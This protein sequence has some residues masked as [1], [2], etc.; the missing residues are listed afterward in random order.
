MKLSRRMGPSPA[1]LLTHLSI[2]AALVGG[3]TWLVKVNNLNDVIHAVGILVACFVDLLWMLRLNADHWLAKRI[4]KVAL[5]KCESELMYMSR[6]MLEEA[7]EKYVRAARH[8]EGGLKIFLENSNTR[9]RLDENLLKEIDPSDAAC[10]RER[11]SI[12]KDRVKETCQEALRRVAAVGNNNEVAKAAIHD[13][14]RIVRVA[15]EQ[16]KTAHE[17]L[18]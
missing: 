14:G 9:R 6:E 7:G 12:I 5:E 3:W 4:V 10:L 8:F 15:A 11:F 13:A 18:T 16:V 17:M 2:V 1:E